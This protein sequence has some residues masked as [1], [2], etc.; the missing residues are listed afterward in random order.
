[1]KLLTNFI[2]CILFATSLTGCI[3]IGDRHSDDDNN[4]W[5]KI[6][7]ENREIISNLY[8]QANRKDIISKLGAP[9]FS[10]AFAKDGDEY[11]ILYYR[12]QHRHSDGDTTKDETT[13]LV[14]KN[15]KLLGWGEKA[16][17]LLEQ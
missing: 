7:K 13:P 16:L 6:Q 12:A 9:N 3:V 2:I 4:S 14:F 1:M 15:D 8:V 5:E 11:R 10:E 17:K